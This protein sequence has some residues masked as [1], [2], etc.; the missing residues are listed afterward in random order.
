MEDN[1][2]HSGKGV[3]TLSKKGSNRAIVGFA[4]AI[5]S[6]VG[7][8]FPLPGI[9]LAVAGL[10]VSFSATKSRRRPFAVAGLLI[11]IFFLILITHGASRVGGF[12]V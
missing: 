5:L 3:Q 11:S 8:F 6:A 2:G 7:L 9:A 10:I 12:D 1:D 4:I